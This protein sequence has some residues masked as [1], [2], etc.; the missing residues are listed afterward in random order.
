VKIIV[1]IGMGNTVCGINW[2]VIDSSA[3]SRRLVKAGRLC[4]LGSIDVYF[5]ELALGNLVLMAI[6]R[7]NCLVFGFFGK[8]W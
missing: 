5:G 6:E 7:L 4:Y 8:G 3:S 1:K 2:L